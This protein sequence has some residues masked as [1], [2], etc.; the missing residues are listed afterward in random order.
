MTTQPRP[1][2]VLNLAAEE[3]GHAAARGDKE[4][5]HEVISKVTATVAERSDFIRKVLIVD[6]LK[7]T[8]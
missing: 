6:A 7:E 4:T 5:F 8:K 1:Q 2:P 3:A